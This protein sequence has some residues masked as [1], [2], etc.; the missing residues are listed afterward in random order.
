MNH[1][2]NP[3]KRGEPKAGVSNMYYEPKYRIDKRMDQMVADWD[4]EKSPTTAWVLEEAPQVEKSKL[5]GIKKHWKHIINKIVLNFLVSLF[6]FAS[7]TNVGI[8]LQKGSKQ[9]NSDSSLVFNTDFQF[10]TSDR[11]N[12]VAHPI[13]SF[14]TF[15]LMFIPGLVLALYLC[16]SQRRVFKFFNQNKTKEQN[17][18]DDEEDDEDEEEQEDQSD[19]TN[20]TLCSSETCLL[21]FLVVLLVL[22]FP[23]G[24]MTAQLT[25]IFLL[26]ADK[27]EL[28]KPVS[29]ITNGAMG[30]EAF[31]ESGPQTVLQ[32]YIIFNTKKLLP[33]QAVSIG[34]SI[35]TLA[36]TAI[37]Y[38]YLMYEADHRGVTFIRTLRYLASVL[39]L[40]FTSAYFKISSI[41]VTAIYLKFLAFIPMGLIYFLLLL[42]ARR[43]KF[44]CGDAFVLSVTN[45]T[46]VCIGPS[47]SRKVEDS[48]YKFILA[49]IA[50][51][52]TILQTCLGVLLYL[53]N[54]ESSRF[55]ESRDWPKLMLNPKQEDDLKKL[56]FIILS[57][58]F[59][60]VTNICLVLASKY[61]NLR[62][63]RSAAQVVKAMENEH[64]EFLALKKEEQIEEV[65]RLIQKGNKS[66]E[67]ISY[68]LQISK[69][70]D[71]KKGNKNLL[72]WA[73]EQQNWDLF[74]ELMSPDNVDVNVRDVNGKTPATVAIYVKN[75]EMLKVLLRRKSLNINQ[76]GQKGTPLTLAIKMGYKAAINEVLQHDHINL[77]ILDEQEFTPLTTAI[78]RGEEY[79]VKVL[80]HHNSMLSPCILSSRQKSRLKSR[81]TTD[82]FMGWSPLTMTILKGYVGIL[83]ILLNY[84]ELQFDINAIL[85]N[86]FNPLTWAIWKGKSDLFELVLK[87]DVDIN[88]PDDW[89]HT[90]AF[91]ALEYNRPT[92]LNILMERE[93]FDKSNTVLKESIH[94]MIEE[95][96]MNLTSA[97]VRNNKTRFENLL[98]NMKQEYIYLGKNLM[99]PLITAI[100]YNRPNMVESLLEFYDGTGS[101]VIDSFT[102][103]SCLQHALLS[104][105]SVLKVIETYGKSMGL[106][107][108]EEMIENNTDLDINMIYRSF[109]L[110][111]YSIVKGRGKMF[112]LLLSS[113]KV[114]V[115]KPDEKGRT[116]L[117]EAV[118]Y[119]RVDM[120][121]TL[122]SRPELDINQVGRG[123]WTALTRAVSPEGSEEITNLI[124]EHPEVDVNKE[125]E[126]HQTPA[127]SALMSGSIEIL[128]RIIL[129]SNYDQRHWRHALLSELET[130]EDIDV[131]RK[132]YA[133]L[134]PLQH[135]TGDVKTLFDMMTKSEYSTLKS[136]SGLRSSVRD[137]RANT[138]Q[139]NLRRTQS[140]CSHIVEI[141]QSIPL[142]DE[143]NESPK[144]KGTL[145]KLNQLY[146]L[147]ALAFNPSFGPTSTSEALL[148]MRQRMQDLSAS[149]SEEQ[150]EKSSS[151]L[152]VS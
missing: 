87:Q 83:E 44:S 49:S 108:L 45:V 74:N 91:Y 151:Y 107:G 105:M 121:R 62:S 126:R 118:A 60:G 4:V 58:I 142:Q 41:A 66:P 102:W 7:D 112:E 147:T 109:T 115:N 25:E 103:H 39:P 36:K 135:A 48:R 93:D 57:I 113:H 111:T 145:N 20:D 146:N 67:F 24:V 80:M 122:L 19:E 23:L 46:V 29:F 15:A 89:T 27:P 75:L 71:Q 117:T 56:N 65:K 152:E 116:A 54:S 47:K 21:V 10:P 53:F 1:E 38:D 138:N 140:A 43:M 30:L 86:R 143:V 148:N 134:T 9:T 32:F 64:F 63:D 26:V 132:G 51:C 88:I 72:I 68:I 13:W 94:D 124:L 130:R 14:L 61:S 81:I 33:T 101:A 34:I 139:I 31:L 100:K 84:T 149:A 106:P 133:G 59:T 114:D 128:R 2:N 18:L 22:C 136:S 55:H 77:T 119:Q 150:I 85:P 97:I 50:I 98:Q 129:G 35:F 70:E 8:E 12:A 82:M 125:D 99:D 40:Y 69:G 6:D 73:I 92:M 78:W 3:V 79:L 16:F 104:S 137:L 120:L 144:K 95:N 37:M 123:G 11:K 28:L 131:T 96:D 5:S 141:S 127:Q 76:S 17:M 52:F 42:S 90:P 110:I